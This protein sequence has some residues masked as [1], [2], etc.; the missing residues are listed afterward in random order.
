MTTKTDLKKVQAALDRAAKNAVSGPKEARTGQY[1][2]A[3]SKTGA[4]SSPTQETT[5]R[6]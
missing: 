5:K 4:A 6:S 2:L 1:T 3:K